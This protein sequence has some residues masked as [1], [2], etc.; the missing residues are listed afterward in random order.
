[1]S[2]STSL[3]QKN[4]IPESEMNGNCVRWLKWCA[5]FR[6]AAAIALA[7]VP[8]L[9]Q[10]AMSLKDAVRVAVQQNASI[11]ASRAAEKA[12]GHRIDQA[13]AGYLPKVN[14]TESWTRSDNPVFVFSSLLTEHQFGAAD[15]QIGPLNRPDFLNNFQSL[16]TVEETVYDGGVTHRAVQSA[17]LDTRIAGESRRLTESGIVAEV[18]RAYEGQLLSAERLKAAEQSLKSARAD[19]ERAQSIRSA[20][21]STDADVLSIRVHVAEVEEQ[22]IR[23]AADLEVARSALNEALGLPLDTPHTLASALTPV[24]PPEKSEADYESSAVAD[25]AEAR[26]ARLAVSVAENQAKDAHGR[27]L[28]QVVVHGAWEADRQDFYDKGGANWLASVGLKWNLFSGFSDK[29]KIEEA[30]SR[31]EGS[32]AE[33]ERAGSEIRLQVRRAWEDLRASGERIKVAE[34][35]VAEAEE[36]LRITQNRYAA[37]MGNVTDLLRT[38]T[39]VLE[40]RTRYLAAIHDERIA[41]AMLEMAAG[42]LTADSEVLQ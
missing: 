42:R 27:Y 4:C 3:R 21:M 23:C 13:Q 41:A 2:R 25:R 1:M 26:Q 38:E 7:A 11:T 39:A 37:G 36:S 32:R 6:A 33:Q 14:Y 8:G 31:V 28:P 19:L 17:Q 22:R 24:R 18:V 35:A 34:A 30:E 9:A 16:V 12:A 10:E 40:T 15:F 29:A 20:G 5:R